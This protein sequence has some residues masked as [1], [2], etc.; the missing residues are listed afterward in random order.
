M[1]IE[2]SNTQ[3]DMT[4]VWYEV[5]TICRYITTD[6]SYARGLLFHEYLI[7]LSTGRAC[8][9]QEVLKRGLDMGVDLDS[10]IIESAGWVDFSEIFRI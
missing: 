8:T 4:N 1:R 9:S 5:P 2:K 6:R 10:V 3:L 7:D